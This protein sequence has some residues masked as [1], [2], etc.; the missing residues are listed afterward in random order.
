[1][2][3]FCTQQNL[4]PQ[5]WNKALRSVRFECHHLQCR[6]HG[7]NVKVCTCNLVHCSYCQYASIDCFMCQLWRTVHSLTADDDSAYQGKDPSTLEQFRARVGSIVRMWSV[8]S[9][10]AVCKYSFTIYWEITV[11]DGGLIF[12]PVQ[13]L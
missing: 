2:Y 13:E 4:H 3:Y 9:N 11:L 8:G 12:V 7:F 10:S 5:S 6:T 1:M